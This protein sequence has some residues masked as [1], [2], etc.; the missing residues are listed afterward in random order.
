MKQ[1]N[2]IKVTNGVYYIDI[3]NANLR[4]LCSS[5]EDVVKHLISKN[6]ISKIEEN[7]LSFESGPNAILL[8][9]LT[10]QNLSFTNLCEFPVLQ[11]LYR[12]GMII[13]SHPNNDGLKPMLIGSPNQVDSQCEYIF[14]GNYG[15]TDIDEL[16]NCGLSKKQAEMLMKIKLKFAFGEIKD[17][18]KLIEKVY[19]ENEKEIHIKNEVYI[20]RLALNVFK[21]TYKNEEIIVDMNLASNLRY[22]SPYDLGFHNIEKNYFSIIHSGQGDGWNKNSPSM[23][24]III[25]QGKIYLIDAGANIKNILNSLGIGINDIEGIFHTHAHDD[26]FVGLTTLLQTD[27]KIKYY[28]T[29]LIRTS[30]FEKLSSLLSLQKEQ[31][32][33]YFH[34]CDLELD[35]WNDING[36][37]VKA[38]L[39]PHPIETNILSFRT[40]G[41]EDYITYSHLADISSFKVLDNMIDDK[42][43][44]SEIKAAYLEK[45]TLKKIDVGGGL[46]HG[47]AKD[48]IEDKSDKIVLAHTETYDYSQIQ[49]VVGSA[50]T[51]GSYDILIPANKDYTR[52]DAS[53]FLTNAF[54]TVRKSEIEILLNCDI[55]TFNPGTIILKERN[56]LKNVF[57]ILSGTVEKITI[58]SK[59][60]KYINSATFIGDDIAITQENAEDTYRTDSYVKALVIPKKIFLHFLKINSLEFPLEEKVIKHDLLNKFSIFEDSLSYLVQSKI[61]D[62]LTVFTFK[63]NQK[64]EFLNSCLNLVIEGS[65]DKIYKHKKICIIKENDFFNEE[66]ILKENTVNYEYIA[67]V[68]TKIYSIPKEIIQNIPI[69]YW[70]IYIKYQEQ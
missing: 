41:K 13:P 69:L 40:F 6:I 48:F 10:I 4:I 62:N 30:V 49:K 32:E 44:L 52:K 50:A 58:K 66:S 68:N 1:I 57:L 12:Q 37:E 14:K 7:G 16:I 26:H 47:D 53:N 61:V 36:L 33:N 23:S 22:L 70:K 8:N 25:F 39:S 21:I 27:H 55:L 11:M 15:I 54:P 18:E 67:C 3:K 29:K 19:L 2:K 51:F 35:K 28:A 64:I 9:D 63:K 43:Y 34:F 59:V 42:N 5:P 31:F 60:S 17:T 56:E 45:A 65:V 46:I 24:S 38:F 20:K